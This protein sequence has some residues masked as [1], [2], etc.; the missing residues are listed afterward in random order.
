MSLIKFA[1]QYIHGTDKYAHGY[2]HAFYAD[3]FEPRQTNVTNFLEI[4]VQRGFSI[5]MWRDF[6]PNATVVGVDINVCPMLENQERVV[7]VTTNAYDK[8][9][10]NLLL[11][12]SFDIIIDD[13]PHTAESWFFL[14]DNYVKKLRPGGVLIIEDIIDPTVTPE[15][16]KCVDTN[17]AKTTVHNMIGKQIDDEMRAYW[18]RGLDVV[19]V[20][21]YMRA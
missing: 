11:D 21:K 7:A 17:I 20:E 5:L 18:S 8:N 9:F 14:L 15:L 4:G 12:E 3:L 16:V 1:E 19:I 2:I 13:G 10:V 6:F